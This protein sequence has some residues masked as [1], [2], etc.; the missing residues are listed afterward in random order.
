MFIVKEA[1]ESLLMDNNLQFL[2]GRDWEFSQGQHFFQNRWWARMLIH[3]IC[4][5]RTS[6]SQ[7]MDG[8]TCNRVEA[9]QA[10]CNAYLP[11]YKVDM[12]PTTPI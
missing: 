10:M 1:M 8:V 11:K 9:Y 3:H 6:S 12:L 7:I 2:T 5:R 4:I